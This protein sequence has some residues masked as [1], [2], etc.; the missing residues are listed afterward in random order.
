MEFLGEKEETYLAEVKMGWRITVFEPIR[1]NLG[2]KVGD[3]LRVTVRKENE[4]VKETFLFKM[5]KSFRITVF[6]EY[7]ENLGLEIGDLVRV[8]IKK[9][10]EGR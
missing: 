5:T 3:R 2:L 4:T 1:K 7:R 10:A 9:E 8:T 6:E